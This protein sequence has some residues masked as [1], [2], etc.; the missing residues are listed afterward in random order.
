MAGV[1]RPVVL[2]PSDEIRL[3]LA[4]DSAPVGL[5]VDGTEAEHLAP[6]GVVTARLLLDAAKVVR[7]SAGTHASRSRV[8]LSLLDLPLRPDQLLDLVPEHVR[9]RLG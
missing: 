5:E 7:L 9:K 4:P 2:G 3:H 6:D 1:S 8:K